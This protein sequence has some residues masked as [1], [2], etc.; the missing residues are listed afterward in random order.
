[1]ERG[2]NAEI[3]AIGGLYRKLYDKQYN[4]EM[5]LFVNPGEDFT[6]EPEKPVVAP[7]G[8]RGAL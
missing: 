5:Y 1:M 4:F 3:I 7:V 6:P 8:S 2:T